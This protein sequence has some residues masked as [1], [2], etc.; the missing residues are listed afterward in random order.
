M[1]IGTTRTYDK[2][3]PRRWKVLRTFPCL[4]I[5]TILT[6]PTM[7][8]LLMICLTPVFLLTACLQQKFPGHGDIAVSWEVISNTFSPN[9]AVRAEFVIQN[10]SD[11]T[12]SDSNWSLWFSQAPRRLLGY[13]TLA[14]L[15]VERINGDWYRV[16]PAQGFMLKPG[17][18]VSFYYDNS[19]WWTKESDAPNGLY[20]VFIDENDNQTLSP[21]T[22]YTLKPFVREEQITRHKN[23][24]QPIPTPQW[25]YRE[26][27]KLTTLN[28]GN[29]QPIIPTPLSLQR[30]NGTVS[31][32]N[33]WRVVAAAGL[34]FESQYLAEQLKQL[35]GISL[36]SSSSAAAKSIVLGIDPSVGESIE[37]YTLQVREDE[38]IEITG[39]AA[40]GVFYGVQSLLAMINPEDFLSAKGTLQLPLV[41]I[42]DAPRFG[43]RGVHVDIARNFRTPGEIK[44]IIDILAFYKI[45]ILHLHLTDDEGWRLEIDALPELTAT[46]AYRAHVNPQQP[47]MIPAYGSGPFK[48]GGFYSRKEFV[49]LIRYA[50][51]RHIDIIPEINL[52]GHARAAIQSMEAR[53]ARFMQQGNEEAA[54]EYRLID[55]EETSQYLSAQLSTDVVINVARESAYRFLTT[56][57]DEV[58]DIYREAE[59]P[60]DIVHIGGDEVPAGAWSRSPMIDKKMKELGNVEIP[61]NMHAYFTSRVKEIFRERNLRMGGWEE[62]AMM[63]TADKKHIPNPAFADGTVIPYVWNNLWGAQDLAY[64]LANIGYPVILSHVTAFYFDL[65]YNNDP[66]EPGLYWGGFTD[67]RSP[68]FYSPYDVFKTTTRDN[69][70]REVDI[71]TEYKDMVRLQPQA[72]PNILGIQAQLWSETILTHNHLEYLL[73]PKLAGL[74]ESAWGKERNW[75][76]MENVGLKQQHAQEQWNAFANALGQRELP[77]MSRLFGGYNYR[78][79]PPGALIDNGTLH[80]N[81]EYPG[82]TIRYTLD[83]SEPGAASTLYTQPVA[84]GGAAVTLAAFDAAGRKS[85]SHRIED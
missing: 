6:I 35:A 22:R 79:P 18:S 38:R 59:A 82:L 64:R 40:A 67:A 56:V 81:V 44:R 26:N 42:E 65:A 73:L 53:Y 71:N 60:L 48:S 19:E 2:N 62:V 27:E 13:D 11:F 68:W 45:N 25:L 7:K 31:L 55:P 52:P 30:G 43:Y 72:R 33:E 20:F 15:Q 8:N 58:V 69:M 49:D 34:E 75:E 5:P 51:Q 21:V 66:L 76:T 24:H 80:A 10:N 4:A 84:T 1:T 78:I 77:R 54:N 14:N 47:G 3:K 16:Y 12:L 36:S 9:A 23:D 29:I 50:Q 85:R 37:S 32:S 83:G 41:Q 46:G 74:A 61:A 63:F 17:E 39:K 57:L 28:P 70:G